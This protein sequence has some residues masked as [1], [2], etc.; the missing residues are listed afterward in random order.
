MAWPAGSAAPTA[1]VLNFAAGQTRANNVL[2]SLGNG[3]LSI[4]PF[5]VGA[6]TVHLLLDV[7][8]WFE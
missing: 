4:R 1:S 8:G 5:V 3:D 2:L 7:S 6:G